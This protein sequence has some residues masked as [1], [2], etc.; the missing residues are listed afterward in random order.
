MRRFP[1]LTVLIL[2]ASGI[3]GYGATPWQPPTLAEVD[4]ALT[5][6]GFDELV[7]TSYRLYVLRSP[8]TVTSMGLAAEFGIRNDALDDYS[9]AYQSETFAIESLILERLR[10][11]D[12]ETL[13]E[14]QRATYDICLWYWDDLVRGQAFASFHYPVHFMTVWSL[15]GF[16]EFT[17]TEDHPFASP[18]DVADY[19]M[20][21]KRVG[22]Q[23]DQIIALLD[24]DARRGIVVPRLPLQWAVGGIRAMATTPSLRHPLYEPLEETAGNVLGL[25][26]EDRDAYLGQAT[27]AIE[28]VVKP[29]YD[30]LL[31]AMYA[32]MSQASSE[33]SVGQFAEGEEAYAHF[34]RHYTQTDLTPAEIHQLGRREVARIQTATRQAAEAL[35]FEDATSMTAIFMQAAAAGGAVAGEG[36][37]EEAQRLIE[38]AE[39]VVLETGALPRLP[40]AD[41]IAIGVDAGGYYSAPPL[42]GSRPGAYYVTTGG[43]GDLYRMP[44]IAYHETVPGH[45]VQIAFAQEIDLP[46]L[47]QN[48]VF[49]GFSEGW[50]LYAERLMSELGGYADDPFGNLGRLQYELLRAVRMVVDTGIHDLGWSFDEAVSYIMENTGDPQGT[51]EYRALRYGLFPGQATA[52]M[53]GLL[54]ILELREMAQEALGEV[55][56]LAEFHDVILGYG[57]VPLL[58]LRE[59]IEDWI[60]VKLG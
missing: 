17:L 1:L 33:I 18:E 34:L 51:A 49:T 10:A 42:D 16:L 53:I 3:L 45:H 30:R 27:L 4:A 56:E 55:F 5:G 7:E 19:V 2:I 47:R 22:E 9:E 41:V 25:S 8:Q 13:T 52:Y 37:V 31:D 12:R 14:A 39:R 24:R 21:L 20:R 44:T 48:V 54:E 29:A 60:A 50:A 35:G 32:L 36:A 43:T 38:K 6:L 46:L 23:F 11:F 57:N 26:A 28:Q 40:R 59:L 58:F 15:P